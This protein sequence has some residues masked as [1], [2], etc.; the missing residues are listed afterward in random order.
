[1][2]TENTKAKVYE[3]RN[4]GEYGT[5][6][7]MFQEKYLEVICNTSF[8][9]YAHTWNSP[10][11]NPFEFLVNMSYG[12]F[13]YKMTQGK[14]YVLD[15][16]AQEELMNQRID[17]LAPLKKWNEDDIGYYKELVEEAVY[18]GTVREEEFKSQII[19]SELFEELYENEYEDIETKKKVD[20]QLQG[21]WNE[22]WIPLIQKLKEENPEKLKELEV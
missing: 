19:H 22:L 13:I 18:G 5:F 20:E 15:S 16:E 1:M 8:G 14:Q 3:V 6:V 2:I 12:T 10:G 4:N 11:S 17:S 9:T 7:L 21:L